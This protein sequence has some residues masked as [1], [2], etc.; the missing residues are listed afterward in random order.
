MFGALK[1]VLLSTEFPGAVFR[2]KVI[3]V[4]VFVL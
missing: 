3:Y 1:T 2:L 4:F